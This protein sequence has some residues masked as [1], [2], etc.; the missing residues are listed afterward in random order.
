[1]SGLRE[2]AVA[3]HEID[4]LDTKARGMNAR[5]Y[6]LKLRSTTNSPA[7]VRAELRAVRDLAGDVVAGTSEVLGR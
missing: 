2:P 3:A 6:R 5:L 7:S 4:A 1:V